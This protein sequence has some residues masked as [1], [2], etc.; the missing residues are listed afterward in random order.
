MFQIKKE[1]L[2]KTINYL[3]N[4]PYIEVFKIINDLQKSEEIKEDINN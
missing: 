1:V 2:E 3:V 4:K